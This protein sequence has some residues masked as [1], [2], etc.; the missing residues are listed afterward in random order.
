MFTCK[1][2][3]IVKRFYNLAKRFYP[4]SDIFRDEEKMQQNDTN[5]MC[6]NLVIYPFNELIQEFT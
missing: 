6:S 2:R 1:K 4:I 3:T 5:G